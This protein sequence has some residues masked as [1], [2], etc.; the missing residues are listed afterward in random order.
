MKKYIV[1]C[2]KEWNIINYEKFIGSANRNWQILTS[3]SELNIETLNEVR[4]RYIFFPHWSWLCI[5]R[6]CLVTR[7]YIQLGHPHLYWIRT[8][9]LK[10]YPQDADRS[11][12]FWHYSC[13]YS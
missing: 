5:Q 11:I 13:G 4:P 10:P 12:D 9:L 1:A 6:S 2:I 8:H 7:R 3:P